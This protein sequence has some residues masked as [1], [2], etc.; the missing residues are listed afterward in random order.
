ME[1]I[2]AYCKDILVEPVADKMRHKPT[3]DA[4]ARGKN[5]KMDKDYPYHCPKLDMACRHTTM[6]RKRLSTRTRVR[7][8]FCLSAL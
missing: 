3:I 8:S 7:K 4:G 5:G 2:L 1:Q 6:A